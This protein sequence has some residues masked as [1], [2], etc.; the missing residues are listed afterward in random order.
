V[1]QLVKWDY[2]LRSGIQLREVIDRAI[3][4]AM[5]IPCG[6]VYLS[7]PREVLAADYPSKRFIEQPRISPAFKAGPNSDGVDTLAGAFVAARHPVIV[8]TS[9]GRDPS[10]VS[11]L[12]E[13]ARRH[14]IGIVESRSRYVNA[15]RS[16]P[17]H[18][19]YDIE[20]LIDDI[21]VLCFVDCDVPWIPALGNPRMDAF[22]AQC[23]S[24]PLAERYPMRSHRSDLTIAANAVE[25]FS[26]LDAVLD[27]HGKP[28]TSERLEWLNRTADSSRRSTAEKIEADRSD[29]GLISKVYLSNCL[30]LL[31]PEST[32]IFSEYWIDR[33][34][35]APTEPGSYFDLPA[36]G[37]LGWAL[38][39]AIGHLRCTTRGPVVAVVGDGAFI[40]SNPLACFQAMAANDLSIL[41]IVCNNGRWGAV[42]RATEW[43]YPRGSATENLSSPLSQL[44]GAGSFEGVMAACGG[45]GLRVEDRSE[46]PDAL[47][48]AF[49][50]VGSGRPCLLN[51]IC[52]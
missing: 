2:E 41:T 3:A 18:L 14:S 47:A 48:Q 36:A 39:A 31:A 5:S 26:A 25:L 28:I 46:L 52:P 35:L 37:G 21:D 50:I 16:H 43:M 23:G 42:D 32:V 27:R 22:V 4:V 8:T 24:A 29:G 19:G 45:V 20:P 9:S 11:L 17:F 49:E 51:L 33:E 12:N 6:P 30:S 44:E 15:S 7:L 40:F 38:P 10:S 34:A 1:R 13:L